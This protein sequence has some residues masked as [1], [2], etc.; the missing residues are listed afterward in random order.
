M[1]LEYAARKWSRAR[2]VVLLIDEVPAELFPRYVFLVTS[3]PAP[4]TT[5]PSL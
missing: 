4:P 1:E 5:K 2:R 3:A